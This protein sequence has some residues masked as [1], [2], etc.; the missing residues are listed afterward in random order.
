MLFYLSKDPALN[1]ETEIEI[2]KKLNHVS[3]AVTNDP[4]SN[5]FI[6]K[7]GGVGVKCKALQ[8]KKAGINLGSLICV[9]MCVY[10]YMQVFSCHLAKSFTLTFWKDKTV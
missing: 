10:A 5:S 4:Y 1:V 6:S 3:I 8:C 7:Y 9:C 2:L